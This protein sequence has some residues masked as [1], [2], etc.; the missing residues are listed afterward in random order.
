MQVKYVIFPL[1]CS[2][3]YCFGTAGF[4]VCLFSF[5]RGGGG[6]L[7]PKSKHPIRWSLFFPRWVKSE[8][9]HSNPSIV[10][11]YSWFW[12]MEFE[13]RLLYKF[14]VKDASAIDLLRSVFVGFRSSWHPF[15]QTHLSSLWDNWQLQPQLMYWQKINISFEAEERRPNTQTRFEHYPPI[16]RVGGS[17]STNRSADN[18]KFFENYYHSYLTAKMQ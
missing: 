18:R 1:H 3:H 17:K 14:L 2:K 12:I 5:F 16:S 9:T 4:F 13:N 10:I 8:Y 15:P 11:S 7:V 6:T